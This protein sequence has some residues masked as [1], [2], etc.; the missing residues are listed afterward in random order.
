[1]S[2]WWFCHNISKN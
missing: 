1:M 2:L